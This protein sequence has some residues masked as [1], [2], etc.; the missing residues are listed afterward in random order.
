ET[1]SAKELL[2]TKNYDTYIEALASAAGDPDE[3]FGVY[4]VTQGGFNV[5]SF[6]DPKVDDLFDKQSRAMDNSERRKLVIE[7]QKVAMESVPQIIFFW[8]R[9]HSIHGPQVKNYV[10]AHSLYLNLK[11]QDV[12]LAQ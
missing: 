1:A 11:F 4:L 8:R 6:S 12:W 3:I 10:Q 9:D 2:V 7:M 5:V